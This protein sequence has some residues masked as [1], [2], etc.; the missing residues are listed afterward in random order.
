MLLILESVILLEGVMF[1]I[2]SPEHR[3]KSTFLLLGAFIAGILAWAWLIHNNV[4]IW[5]LFIAGHIILFAIYLI[6]YYHELTNYVDQQDLKTLL[7][8]YVKIPTCFYLLLIIAV[9]YALFEETTSDD[10]VSVTIILILVFAAGIYNFVENKIIHNLSD[11]QIMKI[12]SQDLRQYIYRKNALV[13]IYSITFSI[14][15]GILYISM[16]DSMNENTAVLIFV[17]ELIINM[18]IYGGCYH[19]VKVKFMAEDQFE[20]PKWQLMVPKRVGVGYTFN[21]NCPFTYIILGIVVV[22]IIISLL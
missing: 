9:S 19:K 22:I 4:L 21:F 15:V 18:I 1:G 17:L 13:G 5:M 16:L 11:E 14:S 7:K 8:E 20:Y 12:E 6:G 10:F 2:F 3:K